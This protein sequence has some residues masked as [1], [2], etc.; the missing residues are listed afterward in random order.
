MWVNVGGVWVYVAVRECMWVNVSVAWVCMCVPFAELFV[1]GRQASRGLNASRLRA[2]TRLPPPPQLPE[3]PQGRLR[4]VRQQGHARCVTHLPFAIILITIQPSSRAPTY[5]CCMLPRHV[6]CCRV[7]GSAGWT[8]TGARFDLSVFTAVCVSPYVHLSICVLPPCAGSKFSNAEMVA[9]YVDR[10]L[11]QGGEKLSDE[12]V[13]AVPS[14][15]RRCLT[16]LSA[17]DPWH[18]LN[19]S[20]RGIRVAVVSIHTVPHHRCFLSIHFHIHGPPPRPVRSLFS[21]ARWR[22]L[23][24]AW[25]SSSPTSRTRTCS[26]RS[27]GG[28]CVPAWAT[29]SVRR[30]AGQRCRGLPPRCCRCL[31]PPHVQ[32]ACQLLSRAHCLPALLSWPLPSRIHL[33]APPVPSVRSARPR[34]SRSTSP[35]FLSFRISST[36]FHHPSPLLRAALQAHPRGPLRLQRRGAEHDPQAQAPLRRAS[37]YILPFCCCRHGSNDTRELTLLSEYYTRLELLP[38]V[39]LLGRVPG[40]LCGF[41]GPCQTSTWPWR[42][43]PLTFS[44]PLHLF[45]LSSAVCSLYFYFIC[46]SATCTLYVLLPVPL[47]AVHLQDGGHA[48]RP[49][50]RGDAGC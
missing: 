31:L 5:A 35:R 38:V 10:L 18:P 22:R 17:G 46:L 43:P 30:M 3:G 20:V 28:R 44:G 50:D 14:R 29:D 19:A 37:A 48:E 16:R 7:L 49:R 13:R 23:S 12:Q 9:T 2:P 21:F 4:D 34:P 36:L 32:W 26:G 33:P 41:L 47:P 40:L 8:L 45:S 15:F 11:K 24:S 27:T 1:Q 25:C 39:L 42:G 6:R